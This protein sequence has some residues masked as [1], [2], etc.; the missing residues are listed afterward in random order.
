MQLLLE[1]EIHSN[2]QTYWAQFASATDSLLKY[3]LIFQWDFLI[4]L[5]EY[6]AA[7]V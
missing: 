5:F 6:F 3:G 7:S 2:L 1:H 4:A